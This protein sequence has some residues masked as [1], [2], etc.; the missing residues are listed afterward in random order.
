M[1]TKPFIGYDPDIRQVLGGNLQETHPLLRGEEH[2]LTKGIV[3]DRDHDLVEHGGHPCDHVQMPYGDRIVGPWAKRHI[4]R[5]FLL[6][7]IMMTLVSPYTRSKMGSRQSGTA[8]A[9]GPSITT[10]PSPRRSRQQGF[11]LCFNFRKHSI[12]RVYKEQIKWSRLGRE[13]RDRVKR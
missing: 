3:Y 4:H 13:A 1:T 6:M 12:G 10:A 2:A 5:S 9:F 7:P 8:I 11:K